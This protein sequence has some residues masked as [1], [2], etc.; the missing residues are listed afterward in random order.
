MES[1]IH[2]GG[3]SKSFGPVRAVQNLSLDIPRGQLF[4][5]LG[6][7]GAGKTT[8]IKMLCG[9]LYPDAGDIRIG[10]RDLRADPLSVRRITGYIPDFPFLYERLTAAEFFD[11]SG[12]LYGLPAVEIRGRREE[13]FVEFGISDYAHTLIKDLS[14]GYRQ[15]LIYAVTLLHRPEVL[16]VDEPFIGLDPFTIRLIKNLLREQ[17]GAGMTIFLT[18]HILALIEDLADRIGIIVGGRLVAAG[19]RSELERASPAAGGSLEEIFFSLAGPERPAGG[20]GIHA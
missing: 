20:T 16:F 12:E 6:P 18:T 4:C 2:V 17:A 14:H 5:F 3:I 19:T 11:F 8:T 13:S 15:R 10:G 1:M 7:N 9:L